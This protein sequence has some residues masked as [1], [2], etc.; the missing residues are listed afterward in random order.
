MKSQ[1]LSNDEVNNLF[2]YGTLQQGQSRNYILKGIPFK[3]AV[4]H[5][6]RK[7]E[8]E[9][10]GYPIIIK[11]YPSEVKGEIYFDLSPKLIEAIDQMEDEGILYHRIV[12]KVKTYQGEIFKAFTYFP[13]EKLINHDL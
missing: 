12:V 8:L 13:T 7:I 4:L 10:L 6:Y 5:N 1:E 9:E 11:E 2:V 3:K